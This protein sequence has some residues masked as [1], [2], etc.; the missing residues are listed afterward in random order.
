MTAR[1][2]KSV[3]VQAF[4]QATGIDSLRRVAAILRLAGVLHCATHDSLDTCACLNELRRQA[5]H[6]VL[7]DAIQEL[8]DAL[9]E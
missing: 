1:F 2:A 7:P 6:Q 4:K 8:A 9:P 3:M 5:L